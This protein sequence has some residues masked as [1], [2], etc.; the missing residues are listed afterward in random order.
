MPVSTSTVATPI[1]PC[2]HIG[3]HPDT[4]MKSTP[5]SA[6]GRV[7]GCRIAPDIAEWPARLVHQQGA[8]M[9]HVLHEVRRRSA[10]VAPGITP[11]PPVI[12][13]VGMPSVCESTACRTRRALT[14]VSPAR[15]R[16]PTRWPYGRARSCWGRSG[17]RG[18]RDLPF[19]TLGLV[20]AAAL[21]EDFWRATRSVKERSF[22]LYPENFIAAC[23]I[24]ILS[25]LPLTGLAWWE[26]LGLPSQVLGMLTV[27]GILL[28]LAGIWGHIRLVRVLPARE[29]KSD[30]NAL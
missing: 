23:L 20:F 8:Q 9:V 28:I 25:L 7:G 17:W 2:P 5:K 29:A 16:A 3:R 21:F 13:R 24:L 30:D 1:V 19:S 27:I 6:S 26:K 22:R 10:M 11:T 12:T 14:P 4:S 18:G 15:Q